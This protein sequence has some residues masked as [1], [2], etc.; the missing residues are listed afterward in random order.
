MRITGHGVEDAIRHTGLF[1]Q[2]EQRKRAE[3]GVVCRFDDPGTPRCQRR[4]KLTGEH[5]HREVPRR[6]C[7]HH[8]HRLTGSQNAGARFDR[9][10]NFT[11]SALGLFG[12]PLNKTGGVLHLAFSFF[13]G[14]AL[15]GGH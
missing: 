5:R 7:R 11:V 9:R 4:T 8:S 15:F 13:Q 1:R 12:K 10:N 14:F 2:R 6:N 3:R